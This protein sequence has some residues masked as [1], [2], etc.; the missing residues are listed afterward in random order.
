MFLTLAAN[1]APSVRP[2]VD[3]ASLPNEF[4]LNELLPEGLFPNEFLPN[5]GGLGVRLKVGLVAPWS[6]GFQWLRES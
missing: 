1:S 3:P 4:L 2:L 6:A 5:E